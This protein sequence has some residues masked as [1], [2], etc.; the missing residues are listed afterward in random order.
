MNECLELIKAWSTDPSTSEDI[1][2]Q[3]GVV[4]EEAKPGKAGKKTSK[5]KKEQKSGAMETAL[6]HFALSRGFDGELQ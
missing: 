4:V 3:G 2:S 6:K 5:A 1:A